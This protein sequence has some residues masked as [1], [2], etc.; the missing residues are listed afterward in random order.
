[1]NDVIIWRPSNSDTAQ[2]AMEIRADLKA[3][4]EA[5]S[6]YTERLAAAGAKL[7]ETRRRLGLA[8]NFTTLG[9]SSPEGKRQ[10]SAWRAWLEQEGISI[11]VA[12]DA[13]RAFRN[14][15][16]AAKQRAKDHVNGGARRAALNKLRP[17]IEKLQTILNMPDAEDAMNW[18][19]A[20]A[21]RETN[22]SEEAA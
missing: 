12:K 3:A 1:M 7:L 15:G 9:N 14:P 22:W 20:M 4:G 13:I 2:L 18:A 21:I 5:K 16:E 11:H 19:I 6:T 17:S 10:M 8:E